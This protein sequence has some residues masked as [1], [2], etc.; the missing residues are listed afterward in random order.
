MGKTRHSSF[1]SSAGSAHL[2]ADATELIENPDNSA[3]TPK[4]KQNV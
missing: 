3:L 1:L 4:H 2:I